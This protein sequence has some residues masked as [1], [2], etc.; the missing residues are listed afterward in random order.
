MDRVWGA[1]FRIESAVPLATEAV[2]VLSILLSLMDWQKRK[3]K[4]P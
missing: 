2:A 4:I 3:Q 1:I